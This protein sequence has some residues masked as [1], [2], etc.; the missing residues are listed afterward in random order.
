M[1]PYV[2]RVLLQPRNWMIHSTGLLQRSW[3]EYEKRRTMDRALMQIQALLDQHTT[4]LTLFQA[5]R[6]SVEESAPVEE[7]VYYLH[8]IVYPSQYEL[9]RDLAERYL[10][11]SV[12]Q[13][14]LAFFRDL[15]LWDEV[16]R[17]YQL[18][19]KPH[20]AELLVRDRLKFG[21]TPY[22]L[23]ALGDITGLTEHYERA[24]EVSGGRF[25]RAKRTLGRMAFDKNNYEESVMHLDQ[26]LTVQPLVAHAWYLKGIA[27]MRLERFGD[28]IMAFTRCIQQDNEIGEAYA[29]IGAVHMKLNNMDKAYTALNDAQRHKPESWMIKENLLTICMSLGRF[30]EAVMHM[31]TLLDLRHKSNRPVHIDELR[32]LASFVA[33][34]TRKL[35]DSKRQDEATK[36]GALESGAVRDEEMPPLARDMEQLLDKV[37]V[38]IKSSADIWDIISEFQNSLGRLRKALEC[39]YREVRALTI[40]PAWCKETAGVDKI[41]IAAEKLVK[42]HTPDVSSITAG[43]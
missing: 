16:V 11:C 17:C 3:L 42:A 27:C 7:R 15:E 14:A 36:G 21:E 37:T 33:V 13:S 32:K 29:N 12:F 25:A 31:N 18:L 30:R 24:W 2:E 23:T 22:M 9:K 8:C 6:K 35:V 38:A 40:D 28:A 19:D 39:R 26:A 34:Q 43:Y 1:F 4:R 20:R 41:V 10:N 5:T